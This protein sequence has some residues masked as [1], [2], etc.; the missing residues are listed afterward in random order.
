MTEHRP[1]YDAASF[2]TE[3]SPSRQSTVSVT[4]PPQQHALD[5][6]LPQDLLLLLPAQRAPQRTGAIRIVRPLE[7]ESVHTSQR[8]LLLLLPILESPYSLE[9]DPVCLH[10]VNLPDGHLGLCNGKT[11][12]ET[13]PCCGLAICREHTSER[14][15][16]LAD[17]DD[18][19][20]DDAALLCTVCAT[21]SN[22]QIY[23]Y[24]AFRLSI[25]GPEHRSAP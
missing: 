5:G 8:D 4:S 21:L 12:G 20:S 19:W 15:L 17:R 14:S 13:C 22:Q 9:Q 18:I 24:H 16:L 3:D 25:N 7:S 2:T 23:A 6:S 1:L 11:E 10:L